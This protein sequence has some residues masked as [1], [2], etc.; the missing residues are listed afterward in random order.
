MRRI[1]YAILLAIALVAGALIGGAVHE[2]ANPA[3]ERIDWVEHAG[4]DPAAGSALR[5]ALFADGRFLA[6]TSDGYQAG[7]LPPALTD[8]I[9]ATVRAGARAWRSSYEV[10]GVV[11]ERIELA[12]VGPAGARIGIANPALNLE[13]PLTLARVVRLLSAADAAV[14]RLPFAPSS[15]R[16]SAEALS[17][18]PDGP[19][20]ALPL[21]FPIADALRPGGVAVSGGDLAILQSIWT[22]LD[23]R[24]DPGHARRF[25]EVD[26]QRWRISWTLDLD[27]IGPLPASADAP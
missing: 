15:L 3:F 16:F 23:S 26:G 22:D 2:A 4:A 7:I 1:P 17:A 9:F 11:G 10:N 19:V 25:V 13:L 24:L 12:F 18:P 8:E 14:A 5:R 20:E 27:A 6:L 21:G